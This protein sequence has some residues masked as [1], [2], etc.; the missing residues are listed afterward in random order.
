MRKK[1][2]NTVTVKF[3]LS[4]VYT[5][6]TKS[7]SVTYRLLREIL[8]TSRVNKTNKQTFAIDYL[9]AFNL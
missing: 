7:K 6:I 3:L 8:F 4:L 9:N 5:L 2:Y 1:S